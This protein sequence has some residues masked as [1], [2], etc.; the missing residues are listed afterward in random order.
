MKLLSWNINGLRAC[1][2]NGFLGTIKDLDADIVCVQE[3][4]ATEEQMADVEF[5]TYHFYQ[6]VPTYYR[7]TSGVAILSKE[8]PLN[9]YRKMES[10]FDDMGR[11]ITAEYPDFFLVTI[12]SPVMFTDKDGNKLGLR[13]YEARRM[14]WE[15]DLRKYVV[16]LRKK[17]VII[18]GDFNVSR[19]PIDCW[20]RVRLDILMESVPKWKSCSALALLIHSDICTLIAVA[21]IRGCHIEKILFGMEVVFVLIIFLFRM[22]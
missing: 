9:I 18:C 11:M 17:S 10:E 6:H 22:T 5:G 13:D 7:G 2:K 1:I 20:E 3:V 21:D 19:G 4:K 12:Y 15:D 8:K 16:R 14:K